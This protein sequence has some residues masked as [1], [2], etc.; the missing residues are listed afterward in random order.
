MPAHPPTRVKMSPEQRDFL[1][2]LRREAK[3]YPPSLRD[4]WNGYIDALLNCR[5]NRERGPQPGERF[6]ALTTA[7]QVV[8]ASVH[9]PS[10][11][12]AR[13]VIEVAEALCRPGYVVL[14]L[15]N[16]NGIAP[17]NDFVGA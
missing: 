8:T 6:R 5:R 17:N 11:V 2:E 1:R 4:D 7:Q 16:G 13:R 12:T 3:S 15:A 9:L 14:R 10:D